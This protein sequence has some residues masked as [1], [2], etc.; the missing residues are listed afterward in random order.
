MWLTFVSYSTVSFSWCGQQGTRHKGENQASGRIKP[1][2]IP[3]RSETD[4]TCHVNTIHLADSDEARSDEMDCFFRN[5]LKWPNHHRQVFKR[6]AR[7]VSFIKLPNIFHSSHRDILSQLSFHLSSRQHHRDYGHQYHYHDHHDHRDYHKHCSSTGQTMSTTATTTPK[8][9]TL[10]GIP[11]RGWCVSDCF[12]LLFNGQLDWDYLRLLAY[13]NY[14]YLFPQWNGMEWHGMAQMRLVAM[15]WSVSSICSDVPKSSSP[16]LLEIVLIASWKVWS[17]GSFMDRITSSQFISI[18]VTHELH[19]WVIVNLS[20][21][22][23]HPHAWILFQTPQLDTIG[24]VYQHRNRN[25]S[26]PET[27]ASLFTRITRAQGR[28]EKIKPVAESNPNRSQTDR[29]QIIHVMLI[30]STWRTQMRL[31]AM[32]WTVSSE[33]FWRDQIII[34]KS[35]KELRDDARCVSFIKL[36]NVFQSS[37]RDILSQC[38]FTCLPANITAT[39]VISTTTTTTTTTATITSTVQ[40]LAELCLQLPQPQNLWLSL[41]YRQLDWDC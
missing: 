1:K 16:I 11:G 18:V 35:S 4:H 20:V 27:F 13:Q 6:T 31:V 22:V 29:R 36:P 23:I 34:A 39:M 15:S 33:M 41:E 3:D 8:S 2:Q 5:V 10:S 26:A 14:L 12:W 38:L 21:I 17:A 37:H 19:V 7:C 9:L 24:R 28:K 30:Q 25:P 32:R 40:A